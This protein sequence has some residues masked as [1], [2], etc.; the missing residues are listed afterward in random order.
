[1]PGTTIPNQFLA[2]DAAYSTAA[3]AAST[4]VWAT[5]LAVL[6]GYTGYIVVSASESPRVDPVYIENA[7]GF[8][9]VVILLN[10]GLDVQFEVVDDTAI[11]PPAIGTIAQ[12][13]SP[14]DGQVS[15][16]CLVMDNGANQARKREGM[17]TLVVR[18]FNAITGLH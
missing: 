17:R 10:K 4:I 11:V 6:S 12:F 16:Y 7:D 18:T 13:V 8:E 14:Y 5:N 15:H 3:P 1:M 9:A 2:V